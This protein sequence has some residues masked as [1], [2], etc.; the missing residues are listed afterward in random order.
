MLSA[1][2]PVDRVSRVN[3]VNRVDDS[4]IREHT[5][6]VPTGLPWSAHGGSA[7]TPPSARPSPLHAPPT[8]A[9]HCAYPRPQTQQW[10]SPAQQAGRN[11]TATVGRIHS[12]ART[13]RL[14]LRC[15]NGIDWSGTEWERWSSA[16]P[17]RSPACAQVL[18]A[19]H[20]KLNVR[21]S[22]E[23]SQRN[24]AGLSG[25]VPLALWATARKL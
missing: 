12:A 23:L 18:R 22:A 13:Q 20:A 17:L 7:G 5:D 6:R 2:R 21:V 24:D 16:Q 19:T 14:P 25:P 3:R 10:A 15:S 1:T 11:A 9:L 8:C 4:T